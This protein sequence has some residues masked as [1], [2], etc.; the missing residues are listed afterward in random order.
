LYELLIDKFAVERERFNHF[1]NNL[2]EVDAALKL[3]RDKA[4]QTANHVLKRVR[5]KLGY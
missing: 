2:E 5:E 1:M 4:M 3:G